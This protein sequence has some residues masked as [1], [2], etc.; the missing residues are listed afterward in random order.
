MALAGPRHYSSN[1]EGDVNADGDVNIADINMVIDDILKGIGNPA[2]DVNQDGDIN[3]ADINQLIKIILEGPVIPVTDNGMYMGIIGYNQTLNTKELSLLDSTTVTEFNDFV[4]SLTT[5]TGRL[6]Y[7]SVDKALDELNTANCPT[8]L[9]N[10]AVIT[11]TKGLDQG[12]LMMTDKY[13]TETEYA[14]ALHARISEERVYGRP[15]KA[16]SVGLLNENIKDTTQ[17]RYNLSALSSDTGKA[18]EVNTMAEVNNRF[19]AIADD[20][21]S[22]NMSE[23][24]TLVFPGVGTGTRIR[25]TLDEIFNN[26]VEDSKVY[27]EGTFSLKTRSLTDITYHGLTCT[28]GD[29]VAAT[30]VDGM[31]VT[32]VFD[33][34]QLDSEERIMK[35]QIREWYWIEDQNAW[36]AS[37]EFSASDLPEIESTYSSALV[38][39]L[40]DCS[41]ILDED[42]PDLKNAANAFIERMENYNTI[43]G[44]FTV[45]GVSFQMVAIDGG[46]FEMGA[47][48]AAIESGL[49]NADEQPRHK[50]TLAPFSIGQ[51]EVT[52][53]L[54]MA[55]M[56]NNP[57]GFTGDLQ[58]PVEQ[59]S[60][61]DCQEFIARL[62]A[63]TGKNF[64][65]PTEAEWEF[66]ARGGI[67]SR[68]TVYAGS[69]VI[70]DV[71]WYYGNSYALGA[72]NANYGTH[73][74][75]TKHGNELGLYDMCGNVFEWCSDWYGPYNEEDQTNP[76]GADEGLRRVTRGG[77]WYSVERD[78]RVTYRNYEGPRSRS[79]SLGLRLAL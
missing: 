50:V 53:E 18:M 42:F 54:W 64:R 35:D 7:Y 36:E 3:I 68:G 9:Q 56:D 78:C 33:G 63:I 59:V 74:V 72:D 48:D 26:N 49:A 57:S 6:L 12:S 51:T 38:M 10:V 77:S 25:F 16:Y 24:L 70:E 43:P 29:S 61:E 79:Y 58:R 2:C 28:A 11:F 13:D 17:F 69:D 75:G 40:L 37:T 55:V 65:L 47:D 45:N 34:I 14:D 76:T 46:T 41:S 22:R 32:L 71:A 5:Q 20:L 52:Q 44:L 67:K 60:W 73:P 66:A 21:V 31:F 23:T 8:N 15:I 4:S 39:M 19:Q 30:S 1:I 27:I 62:N